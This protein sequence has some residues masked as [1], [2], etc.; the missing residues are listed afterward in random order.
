MKFSQLEYKPFDFDALFDNLAKL[1]EKFKKAENA[2]QQYQTYVEIDNLSEDYFTSNALSRVRYFMDTSDEFY[3][4][5][6]AAFAKNNPIYVK[7]FNTL[8]K[9]MIESPYKKYLFEQLGE[10]NLLNI[11]LFSTTISPGIVDDMKEENR[12]VNQYNE[13]VSNLCAEFDG[14]KITLALL[15]KHKQDPNRNV[16]KKAFQA[17]SQCFLEVKDKLD[18]IFDR[19]VKNRTAQARKL[20]FRDYTELGYARR[21]RN[22]YGV[23]H[24][25]SFKQ[26][27]EQ[28][29]V[30]IVKE[31]YKTRCERLGISNLTICDTMLAF[32]EGSPKPQ[33]SGDEIVKASLT[34]Y[35]ELSDKTEAFIKFMLENELFDVYPR[36]GKYP[37]G[38]CSYLIKYNYPFIFSNFNGTGT[39][40]HVFTHEVG[41]ALARY[42]ARQNSKHHIEPTADMSEINSIA[43]E[44]LTA[45][46][47]HLFFKEHADRYKLSHI[48]DGILLIPYACLVDEFQ[49]QVYLNP[50]MSPKQ[51]DEKWLELEK[52][53]RPDIDMSDIPF[54]SSGSGWQRQI[55]IFK[56]PFYYIEYALAQVVAFEFFTKS[57]QNRDTAVNLYMR[58]LECS[59][60]ETFLSL[61]SVLGFDSPFEKGVA[62]S[63]VSRIKQWLDSQQATDLEK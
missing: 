22:C 32:K 19:L 34:V 9:L 4:N 2:K 29:V 40:I 43:M 16:R 14:E 27:V 35:S 7:T 61:L 50:D 59:S 1:I 11:Q 26:Q 24:V 41:H 58:M 13:V 8:F 45:P 31:I 10:I 52:R 33:I 51:R 57:L 20:G 3:K 37:G 56:T 47:Y 39:D 62:S 30:P 63:V 46:W 42:I 15:A 17:E 38:F 12:L 49:Q 55:H 54:Y 5:E 48:E 44:Y 6:V 25:S 28:H 36:K 53:F 21:R 60:S 18:D 23:S